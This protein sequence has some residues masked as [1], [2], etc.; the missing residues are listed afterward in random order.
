MKGEGRHGVSQTHLVS[1]AAAIN[2]DEAEILFL[3]KGSRV[4]AVGLGVF[5]NLFGY[6]YLLHMFIIVSKLTYLL[7]KS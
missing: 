6:W 7:L 4:K 3:L 1:S 2:K 5:D